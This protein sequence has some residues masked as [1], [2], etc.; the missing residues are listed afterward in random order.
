[1]SQNLRVGVRHLRPE[2]FQLVTTAPSTQ[3]NG[4]HKFSDA[5]RYHVVRKIIN[6]GMTL[7]TRRRRDLGGSF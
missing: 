6:P 3:F 2:R 5:D 1:M 4:P 7:E